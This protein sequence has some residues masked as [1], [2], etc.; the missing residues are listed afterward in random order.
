LQTTYNMSFGVQQDLGF[1]T[2]LDVA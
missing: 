2:V 1:S